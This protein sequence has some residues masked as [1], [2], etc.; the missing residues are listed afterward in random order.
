P[1]LL[2]P[3]GTAV[4]PDHVR[5]PV[6]R[7]AGVLAAGRR[8]ALDDAATPEDVLWAVWHE[9]GLGRRWQA[10]SVAGGASGAAA[11]RDLD[12]V[13]Q[14]FDAAAR[15]TDRLPGGTIEG[16]SAHL[17]AQQIPGDSLASATAA[18]E[19]VT[20]LTAHAS[21]GLEWDLVCVAHVQE[22]SWPDLRRRGSLLGCEQLVDVLAGRDTSVALSGPQ[23]AEERRLFYV[24]ATRARQRLVVTAVA[25]D[26][27]QPS[28]FLDELDPVDGERPL[29]AGRRGTHLTSLVAELRAVA[30]DPQTVEFDRQAAAGELSRLAQAGVRGAD[31]DD[32]WGLAPLSDDGPVAD[33]SRPVPVSPSRIDMFLRCEVRAVLQDLGARDG[34]S[35]SQSLG[36]LVHEVAASAPHGATQDELEAMLDEQWPA[37][38]FGARWHAV[39][40]RQRATQILARLLAWL[41]SSRRELD[42]I[43]IER[44]FDAVVGDARLTGRVDRLERDADGRLV[45]IDLKTGKTKVKADDLPVH[46]QLGAYQLAVEAGAF[47]EG[48][49]TGGARLVQLAAPGDAEQQQDPLTEADDPSW[50]GDEVARV[51]ARLRG[52][53]FTAQINSYCGHCDLKVCCP[54]FPEGRQVTS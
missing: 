25:G 49:R 6:E 22:G 32:W 12:A 31:P 47:G 43:A 23:L 36:N 34:D 54:L 18:G 40:E 39:N 37:L 52:H 24:A 11:D 27:E 35:I 8:A 15:Y 19:A 26:D 41:S 13:V 10:A 46:P 38:D 5:R 7:L 2:D 42:L 20:I 29:T 44:E 50:I 9:S 17:A 51:A 1:A 14:L 48:E 45:V 28:R 53:E 21:K 33:P 3:A 4:L 16:F 30:C